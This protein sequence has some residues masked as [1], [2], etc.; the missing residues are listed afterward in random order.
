MILTGQLLLCPLAQ[1]EYARAILTPHLLFGEELNLTWF[2]SPC[3]SLW[4]LLATEHCDCLR[5]LERICNR[6]SNDGAACTNDGLGH[7]TCGEISSCNKAHKRAVATSCRSAQK[8]QAGNQGGKASLQYRRT[9]EPAA[10]TAGIPQLIAVGETG[11]SLR[12]PLTLC[13]LVPA[14]QQMGLAWRPIPIS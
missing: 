3:E 13:R 12:L 14:P 10:D 6:P 9:P 7:F 1:E 4:S 2:Q 8:V 5:R 11:G